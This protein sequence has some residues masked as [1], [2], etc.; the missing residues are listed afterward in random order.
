LTAPPAA[1]GGGP[2]QPEYPIRTPRLHN[3]AS[4]RVM[5]RAG[6]GRE[7]HL[8]QSEFVNGEWTGELIHAVLRSEWAARQPPG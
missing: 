6:L 4:A 2:F 7:A 5:E 8:V 3:T 1:P